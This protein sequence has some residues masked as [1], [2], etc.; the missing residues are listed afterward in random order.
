MGICYA[1]ESRHVMWG[2]EAGRALRVLLFEQDWLATC[3]DG[4][5]T[6][7]YGCN[8]MKDLVVAC[9]QKPLTKKYALYVDVS[10]GNVLFY[11]LTYQHIE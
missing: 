10:I 7:L 2:Y 9:V 4:T 8:I 5:H 3:N 6:L 11:L 1:K